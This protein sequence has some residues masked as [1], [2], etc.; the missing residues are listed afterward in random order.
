[1]KRFVVYERDSDPAD[2]EAVK[3]GFSWPAFFFGWIW[4]FAKR[5]PVHGAVMLAISIAFMAA[6]QLLP[7]EGLVAEIAV[8][9]WWAYSIL[10]GAYGNRWLEESLG[11]R[12]FEEA[13]VLDAESPEEALSLGTPRRELGRAQV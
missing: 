3:R 12:G 11:E 10:L 5:L 2:T 9:L 4:G 7:D 1:M 8:V 13:G 6:D